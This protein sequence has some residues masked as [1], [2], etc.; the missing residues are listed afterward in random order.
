MQERPC[1]SQV[2]R[3]AGRHADKQRGDT[4]QVKK[5]RT[6]T[7]SLHITRTL[8]MATCDPVTYIIDTQEKDSSSFPKEPA[9]NKVLDER[10]QSDKDGGHKL[11]TLIATSQSECLYKL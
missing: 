3:Q 2:A 1:L 8:T 11:L 9:R 4:R 7:P 5:D 10:R 6:A